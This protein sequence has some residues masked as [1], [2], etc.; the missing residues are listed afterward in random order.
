MSVERILE[1]KGLPPEMQP[2]KPVITDKSWPNQ[3]QI[4]IKNVVMKYNDDG[5]VILK[6]ISVNIKPKE[7]VNIFI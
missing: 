3:G 6:D 7:K 4:S 1:Y 5:P 2:D